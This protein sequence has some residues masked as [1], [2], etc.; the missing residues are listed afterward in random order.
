MITT[1]ENLL[2]TIKT[3]IDQL[4]NDQT[5]PRK[6]TMRELINIREYIHAAVEI[7]RDEATPGTQ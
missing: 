3:S 7:M 2:N 1:H 6:Q 4:A 5:V